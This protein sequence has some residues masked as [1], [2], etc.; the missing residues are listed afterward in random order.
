MRH[1]N[2]LALGVVLCCSATSYGDPPPQRARYRV[3]PGERGAGPGFER[4]TFT[5]GPDRAWQL[6]LYEKDVD[7]GE[8]M[9]Q[10]QAVTAV[11]PLLDAASALNFERYRL[12]ISATGE[13]YDYRDANH[14]DRALVPTWSD[15]DRWFVPRPARGTRRKQGFPHTCTY[16]GHVLSL[17]DVQE[18]QSWT[19]WDNAKVLELDRELW[20][21]TGRTSKDQEE[22]RL[23][24]P[25]KQN[26]HYV[27]WTK[28]D[29]ETLIDAGMNVFG[30]VP[31]IESWLRAQPVFYRRGVKGDEPLRWPADLYR[32]NN[33]GPVMYLDEPSCRMTGEAGF[34]EHSFYFT[35]FLAG[36]VSRVQAEVRARTYELERQLRDGR[37][38]LGSMHVAQ[39]D[40]VTWDTRYSTAYYQ[41]LGGVR[42]FVHEGR[43]QLDE[44]NS[45][46]KAT[47]GLDRTHT[48]EEMF[49]YVFAVM[50]GAS[51]PFGAD[52]GIAIYGQADPELN[53]LAVRLAYDMGARY[54]WYWT[55]DHDHHLPWPEQ[56]ELTRGI[57]RHAM[58][59]PRPSIHG[60]QPVRDKLITIPYGYIP[61]LES[62]TNRKHCWDLWWVREMDPEK[63][64]EAS[65][66][67]RRL[68]RRLFEEVHDAL[69]AGE[70]FDITIDGAQPTTGY[71]Q[72]VHVT[73]P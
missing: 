65:Q 13:T 57:K 3:L 44:F 51:R 60:P 26:Y 14:P 20:I 42:G 12:R 35:D 18:S 55:S 15:F 70:D 30:L 34:Y 28:Q 43:Y 66:R 17:R 62:P 50:R 69:D 73:D 33:I 21:A 2:L 36:L 53:P 59:R 5:Y 1:E 31:G 58:E 71:R 9:M 22:R 32:T 27:Q 45:F 16:L 48:A 41:F 49:R 29:Y 47:T 68:M 19:A 38:S 37:V 64:N 56:L 39:P 8:P 24:N 6:D 54:V 72:V 25:A 52:W 63:Q 23:P 11:D 67:Y 7:G 4:V 40:F 10:L 61:V 46:V